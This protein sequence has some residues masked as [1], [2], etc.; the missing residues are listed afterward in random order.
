MLQPGCHTGSF[1]PFCSSLSYLRT[2]VP[3]C[4]TLSHPSQF[5]RSPG[6]D[7]THNSI[8]TCHLGP[9]HG[10]EQPKFWVVGC[11]APLLWALLASSSQV[12]AAE[13]LLGQRS[14][15]SYAGRTTCGCLRQ[16]LGE[17]HIAER[18]CRLCRASCAVWTRLFASLRKGFWKILKR[19]WAASRAAPSRGQGA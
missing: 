16:G 17:L 2:G 6:L 19:P 5:F 8:D 18:V 12:D 3:G 14:A 7:I 4:W 11:T 15:Q 1:W 9:D 10:C 13:S